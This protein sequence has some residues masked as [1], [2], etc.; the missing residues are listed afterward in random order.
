MS[1]WPSIV[2]ELTRRKLSNGFDVAAAQHE[3]YESLLQEAMRTTPA[4]RGSVRLCDRGCRHSTFYVTA[5]DGWTNA[6]LQ[7]VYKYD[8]PSAWAHVVRT[9]R[10]YLIEDVSGAGDFQPLWP[11]VQSH[12]SVPISLGEEIAAVLSLDAFERSA[13]QSDHVSLLLR[14]T[15]ECSNLLAR[16]ALLKVTWLHDLERF[17]ARES[18][19]KTLCDGAV[20]RL[21]NLVGVSGCSIFLIRPGSDTLTLAATTGIKQR[22]DEVPKYELGEGLTGWV[23]K[24]ATTLR[25][26]DTRDQLEL[27]Q[28]GDD[29]RWRNLWPEEVDRFSYLA[30]P[31]V[32]ESRVIG[33]VR[34]AS[35]ETGVDFEVE[36]EILLERVAEGLAVS[37]SNIWTVS[38]IGRLNERLAETLELE[39]VCRVITEQGLRL[40]GY[41]SGHIRVFDPSTRNLRLMSANG[42]LKDMFP[43]IRG[44][45]EGISGVVALT[46]KEQCVTDL[47]AAY[48]L[49]SAVE[50]GGGPPRV[51]LLAKALS[52]ASFPLIVQDELVGTLSMYWATRHTFTAA[53]VNMM[54]GIA[55][56]GALAIR[57]ALLHQHMENEV[58]RR[59]A[60]LAGLHEIVLAFAR[61]QDSQGLLDNVLQAALNEARLTS[62]S[63]WLCNGETWEP[64]A[65]RDELYGDILSHLPASVKVPE[66]RLR[67]V[68][69]HGRPT[70]IP[71][72]A[73]HSTRERITT[74]Y[75]DTLLA[76]L[77]Q[78]YVS[79]LIVPFEIGS[80]Y[81]GL[82]ALSARTSHVFSQS[83]VEY[84]EIL[85]AYAAVAIQLA[86]LRE[87]ANTL[88]LVQP[89]AMMGSMM[90]GFQHELRNV[91]NRLATA[92]DNVEDPGIRFEE[93]PKYT[94]RMRLATDK[95]SSVCSDMALF[96]G[97][98]R[99]TA[100]EAVNLNQAV[101][102]ALDQTTIREHQNIPCDLQFTEPPPVVRG[103]PVQLRHCM[104]FIISNAIEAMPDG[105]RLLIKTTAL[106]DS[107][108]VRVQDTGVG[109]DSVTVARC[110]DPFFTTKGD[111]GGTGLGLS[112][113]EG[114]MKLHGGNIDIDSEPN[115]GTIITLFFP[116]Q[117]TTYYA[118]S[119]DRG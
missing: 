110:R 57:A 8:E 60:P 48:E 80:Q 109:M 56:R 59:A 21:R 36:D 79:A 55:F 94:R 106:A 19:E 24:H 102:A 44:L 41:D 91:A 33:V 9:G 52:V 117:E 81:I 42:P 13:F 3:L 87:D 28:F 88:R 116:R 16:F 111:S 95:L 72:L 105:G 66:D 12:V 34:L 17:L 53:K 43:A 64:K 47:P 46:K 115:R 77:A 86:R 29:L 83:V 39:K 1:A 68:V 74:Q 32:G 10:P 26:R 114:I 101:R 63:I 85:G 73:V 4:K 89:L 78:A 90:S 112:I 58:K 40:V 22:P 96:A 18:D 7:R 65:A 71:D 2:L 11:D 37:I 69:K 31:L 5:G 67:H 107:F 98:G 6:I 20:D 108:K 61:I 84:L 25:L 49:L 113:V 50:A 76:E 92:L 100:I 75:K 104:V 99:G 62:G 82:L 93:I 35:K 51:A 30:A 38:E 14:L 118:E 97:T 23:A 54:R 70:V 15:A 103:N 45:G 27:A 119:T